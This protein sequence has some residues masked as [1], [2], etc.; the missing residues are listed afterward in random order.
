MHSKFHPLPRRGPSASG[1]KQI[2]QVDGK[3]NSQ[4]APRRRNEEEEEEEEDDDD[5]EVEKGDD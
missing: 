2:K 4:V 3:I 1:R 5:E